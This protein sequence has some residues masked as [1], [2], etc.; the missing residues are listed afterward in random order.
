MPKR[1][2]QC[3]GCSACKI[4]AGRHGTL[5][6]LDTTGTLKCPACQAIATAKRNTRPS[7]SARG[8]GWKFS[9]RKAAD[10]TYQEATRCQCTGCPQHTGLCGEQF[11][12][13]NPKTGGHVTPRSRGGGDGPIRAICRRCNSSDG[14][15]LARR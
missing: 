5:F 11:T 9:T 3:T 1:W 8:L 14:G 12:A 10:R 15:R 4:T 2:C 6:D 13:A 7:S